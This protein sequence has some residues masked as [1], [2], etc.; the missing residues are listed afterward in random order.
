MGP[1]LAFFCFLPAEDE[2]FYCCQGGPLAFT[3]CLKMVTN[4]PQHFTAF[5]NVGVY[6]ATANS[7]IILIVTSS[8]VPH[9]CL[10]DCTWQCTPFC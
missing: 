2:S 1:I 6:P 8:P 7:S 10:V 3:C 5:F 9:T 4:D